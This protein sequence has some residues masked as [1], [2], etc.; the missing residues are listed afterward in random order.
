MH[1]VRRPSSY[2]IMTVSI[3][4]PS[5]SRHKYLLVPSR[6]VCSIASASEP[7]RARA[8]SSSR[9]GAGRLDIWAK[10]E[11]PLS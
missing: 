9:S 10:S 1:A 3:S 4:F 5:P 11:T 8:P 7:S 2:G 6:L